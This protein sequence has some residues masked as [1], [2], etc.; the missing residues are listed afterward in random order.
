[1]KSDRI[2]FVLNYIIALSLFFLFFLFVDKMGDDLRIV[3][4]TVTA[5]MI[6]FLVFQ[7]EIERVYREYEILEDGVMM[8]EGIFTKKKIFLPYQGVADIMLRKGIIGRMLNFGDII[9][10]GFK[11]KIVIKGV[12]KPE[13]V[14][15]KIRKKVEEKRRRR[16]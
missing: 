15:E 2:S 10:Q 7:P 8:I 1:M 5:F 9:V 14:Y 4:G 12:K 3:L 11:K 6:S 13:I 16:E